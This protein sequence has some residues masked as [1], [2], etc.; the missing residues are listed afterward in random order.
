ME[1]GDRE[2]VIDEW[3]SEQ[4]RRLGALAPAKRASLRALLG[5]SEPH[6][7]TVSGGRHYFRR[8]DLER[9]LGVLG[10][11]YLDLP[12]FPLVFT[13][14]EEFGERVYAIQ[15]GE[16]SARAFADLLGIGSVNR[17]EDGVYYTYKATVYEFLRR[18]PSLCVITF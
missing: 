6:V 11:K 9:A 7:D 17:T 14:R 15:G 12:L 18:Y 13:L 8:E 4:M 5:M 1:V 3:L 2:G 16:H 10:S